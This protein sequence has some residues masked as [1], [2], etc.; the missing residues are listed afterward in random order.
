[1]LILSDFSEGMVKMVWDK[2]SSHNN[3]LSQK[4]DIQ[5]IPFPDN[6]FDVV[7]ANHMLYHVP[8]LSKAISEVHRVMRT[9]GKFYAA[10]NGNGGMRTYLHNV[11][12]LIN[13]NTPKLSDGFSFSLQNGKE[14]LSEYFSD[15]QSYNY[16]DTLHITETQDLIDWIKST[17]A[18]SNYSESD[19]D[20]L[21]S[22]FENIRIKHGAIDIPKELGLFVSTK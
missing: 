20:K 4:I 13:P 2:Y 21:Y 5:N 3:I 11:R 14:L 18:I 7:I 22:Y 12:K 6:C 19:F 9:G 8:D 1:T 10:T 16:D 15:V 17:I